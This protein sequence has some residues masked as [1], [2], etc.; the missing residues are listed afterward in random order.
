M[1]KNNINEGTTMECNSGEIKGRKESVVPAES[2]GKSYRRIYPF[3]V[4]LRLRVLQIVCGITFLIIGTV[5]FI[6]EKGEFN[7]GLGIFAG[8]ATVLAAAFSIHTTR[9]FSGYKTTSPCLS[10]SPLR[11]LG[12]TVRLAVP[13]TILWATACVTL[14]ALVVQALRTLAILTPPMDNRR[15][16]TDKRGSNLLNDQNMSMRASYRDLTI[17]A[18]IELILAIVTLCAVGILIRIDCKYDPD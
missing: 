16:N 13:L 9:G 12:P 15:I 14:S 4:V 17:L 2:A 18:S 3:A 6:E 5:A 11:F 7:L 1:D 8:A 10:E